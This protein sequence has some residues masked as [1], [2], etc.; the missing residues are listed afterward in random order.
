MSETL[1]IDAVRRITAIMTF[2]FGIH[3]L[4]ITQVALN[5]GAVILGGRRSILPNTSHQ[6]YQLFATVFVAME[7]IQRSFTPNTSLANLRPEKYR[8]IPESTLN[9]TLKDIHD[10][11]QYGVVHR[12]KFP[13][14]RSVLGAADETLTLCLAIMNKNIDK[15]KFGNQD[16]ICVVLQYMMSTS[17]DIM[18]LGSN[19]IALVSRQSHPVRLVMEI[20]GNWVDKS[21]TA[22]FVESVDD[23]NEW[24]SNFANSK[25]TM[26][27]EMDVELVLG[28]KL[29]NSISW[30]SG[31]AIL[32]ILSHAFDIL[33]WPA[34]VVVTSNQ[35]FIRHPNRH[36]EKY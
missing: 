7:Y 12:V 31:I 33:I 28:W 18:A 26:S 32:T 2:I 22:G 8:E 19:T 30:N 14:S 5:V 13:A 10:F 24:L 9:D 1:S 11:L 15:N 16:R 25:R 4:P 20:P 3:Y 6:L 21:L 36:R 27:F 34:N 23:W 35:T 29:I 17:D